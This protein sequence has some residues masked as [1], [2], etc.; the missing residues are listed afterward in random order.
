MAEKA[1]TL[2]SAPASSGAPEPIPTGR[3]WATSLGMLTFGLG[4]VTAQW[5][6]ALMGIVYS[7]MTAAAMWQNFRARLPFLYD[8]WSEQLPPPPTLMHAMI[9]I[10]TLVEGGA[11]ATGIV[12]W[13]V[14]GDNLG[15]VWGV[16]SGSCAVLVS[17][18][19]A[20]FLSERGVGLAEVWCWREPAQANV[21]DNAWWKGEGTNSGR[22]CMTVGIG[23]VG[24]VVL[25]LVAKG[26]LALLLHL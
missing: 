20:I 17:L 23:L 2:A 8:P 15:V 14:G 26:Y 19:V 4:L 12:I 21:P 3:R 7:W 24:G 16:L 18:G 11:L 9:A 25:G 13:F 22:W 5:P 10:S 6:L 1:V